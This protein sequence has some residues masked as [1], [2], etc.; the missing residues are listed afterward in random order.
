MIPLSQIDQ[1]RLRCHCTRIRI[2]CK[3]FFADPENMKRFEEWK[4][5]R[6]A[7]KKDEGVAGGNGPAGKQEILSS[8][9]V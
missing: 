5:A 6:D 2:E 7:R 8:I 4:E 3:A 9:P 1:V